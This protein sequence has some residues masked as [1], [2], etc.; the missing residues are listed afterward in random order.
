MRAWFP[1]ITSTF[2]PTGSGSEILLRDAEQVAVRLADDVFE[3][4]G[5]ANDVFGRCAGDT[6]DQRTAQ[7]AERTAGTAAGLRAGNAARRP[8]DQCA[9]G[10][11]RADAHLAHTDDDALV[12]LVRL[13][14]GTGGIGV[15]RV[16][17]PAAGK[18]G[19]QGGGKGEA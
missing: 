13:L 19:S 17:R 4:A 12:H 15:G 1:A 5:V 11:R 10:A 7:G 14:H 18:G 8:A 6:A 3:G 16:V 2:W 9:G